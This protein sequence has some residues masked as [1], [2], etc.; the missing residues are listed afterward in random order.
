MSRSQIVVFEPPPAFG[1]T[2]QQIVPRHASRHL[3]LHQQSLR[4][5]QAQNILQRFAQVTSCMEYIRGQNQIES[6]LFE[7]LLSR[8]FL[9]IEKLVSNKRELSETAFGVHKKPL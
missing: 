8:G 5:Q 9:G 3:K 6:P 1:Y 2:K 4:R 7:S